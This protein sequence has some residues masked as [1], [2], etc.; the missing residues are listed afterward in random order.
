M[1]T[2][3]PNYP[4]LL[5]IA[6]ALGSLV[7]EVVFVGVSTAG[8]LLTDPLADAVRATR[9]VDAIVDAASL[10][11]FYEVEAQLEA[12]GFARDIDSGIVCRWKHG[13]SGI[14]LD[15]MPIDPRVLGFANR[16]YPEAVE[17]AME[18]RLTQDLVIRIASAPAFVATKFEAFSTRGRNDLMS[19]HDLEDILNVIDGRPQIE[20]EIEAATA[21]L[22]D[23]VKSAIAKLLRHPDFE[24][25]L[26]GLVLDADRADEVIARLRRIAA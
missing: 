13:A 19:S 23:A 22:R 17:S 2:N 24:N 21:A 20:L 6:A 11:R 18:V 3:D 12:R 7:H 15:L 8:L 5:G 26:P 14:A 10:A 1:R 16:W 9:D 25:C 4:Q